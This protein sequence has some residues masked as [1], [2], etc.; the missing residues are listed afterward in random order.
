MSRNF[1]RPGVSPGTRLDA[2]LVGTLQY[3]F[4]TQ[5]KYDLA[6]VALQLNMEYGD[7]YAYVSGRR[8]MPVEL[9]KRITELTGDKIFLDT[10]FAGS[11][12][13]WEFIRNPNKHSGDPVKESLDVFS[14]VGEI[15]TVLRKAMEDTRISDT[16]RRELI[17]KIALASKELN[18][19]RDSLAIR[20]EA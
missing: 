13:R 16:E 14:A 6:K 20:K 11:A 17:N 1:P 9:L 5:R 7:L 12:I 3:V 15:S 18:D 8:T 10:V 19:L 2:E 4:I